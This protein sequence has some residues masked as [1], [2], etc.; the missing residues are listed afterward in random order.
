MTFFVIAF[1]LCI[2]LYSISHFIGCFNWFVCL[3]FLGAFLWSGSVD[4][5][6]RVW[7]LA[8][9]KCLATLAAAHGGPGHTQAVTCLEFVPNA[10]AEPFIASGAADN[11]VKLWGTSGN[12][13]HTVTHGAMVTSLKAFKDSLGG[14]NKRF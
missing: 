10:G 13:L 3:L 12:L 7:D 1:C 5:T 8:S 4:S 2:H 9:G 11:A 14:K 6:L